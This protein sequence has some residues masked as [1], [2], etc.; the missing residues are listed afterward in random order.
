[1][2]LRLTTL[3][4]ALALSA[5]LAALYSFGISNQL[6]FDDGRLTDGTVFGQYGKLLQLKSRMLS[7]G[8]FVWIQDILGEGW[9]K[10]RIV[11]IVLHIET[12]LTLYAFVL[13]LLQLL[14]SRAVQC[15]G[16]GCDSFTEKTCT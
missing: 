5:G 7:Y 2:T 9:W 15:C 6:V 16:L 10:Q 3:L 11:N 4:Y 13:Q 14:P 8:S 12:A 1:M